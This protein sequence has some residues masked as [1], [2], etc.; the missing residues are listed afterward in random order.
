MNSRTRPSL[1]PTSNRQTLAAKTID[2]NPVLPHV[3]IS[4][5]E[6]PFRMIRHH[7]RSGPDRLVQSPCS[8]PSRWRYGRG[9]HRPVFEP[10]L[11]AQSRSSVRQGHNL[12]RS[13][14]M[15]GLSRAVPAGLRV[16]DGPRLGRSDHF[17]INRAVDQCVAECG[18]TGEDT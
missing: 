5:P 1:I 15:P 9:Q 14:R 8:W 3:Y 12:D 4:D 11:R 18:K 17:Q 10:D 2:A 13:A 7:A 16:A 6:L